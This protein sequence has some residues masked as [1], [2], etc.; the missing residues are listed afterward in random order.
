MKT[1]S[2]YNKGYFIEMGLVLGI[3]LGIPIGLVLGSIAYGPLIG[4][5]IG[6][7]VGTVLEKK[8]NKNPIELTKAEKSRKNKVYWILF[9][10]G[11]L[12]FAGFLMHKILN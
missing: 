7:T 2:G 9:I 11:S 4:S 3:P 8:L 10:I 12:I 5:I 6:L 1:E